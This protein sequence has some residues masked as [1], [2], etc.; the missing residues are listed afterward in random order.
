M[1]QFKH[2]PTSNNRITSSFGWRA[3]NGGGFHNGLDF[4]AVVAGRDG[5]PLFAVNDG[6]VAR[7]YKSTSY[8]Y[9]VIIQHDGW[10]SL[11]AHLQNLIVKTG[12]K[13]VSGQVVAK[14]GNTGI[15]QATHLH[16][17]VRDCLY[18]DKFWVR[19]GADT[20]KYKYCVD[21]KPFI[22]EQI[23]GGRYMSADEVIMNSNLDRPEDW[24]A[25][26]NKLKELAKVAPNDLRL[27]E[28]IDAFI[29]KIGNR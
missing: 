12:Q 29:E 19:D 10:C 4:G 9:C 25:Y 5:D 21:P 3:F 8:G 23:R 26:K 18:D 22:D 14:M 15:S 24:I 27:G 20:K 11:Y 16:F 13:V 1:I 2:L 28:F 17:E 7:A 6:F